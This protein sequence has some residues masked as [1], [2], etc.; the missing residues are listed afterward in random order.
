MKEDF[1]GERIAA[2]LQYYE[3][4]LKQ[5]MYVSDEFTGFC[6]VEV[7][8][9]LNKELGIDLVLEHKSAIEQFN[10]KFK[11]IVPPTSAPSS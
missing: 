3:K 9:E 11:K 4:L 8:N 1:N 5:F 2:L 10:T 7:M 6:I